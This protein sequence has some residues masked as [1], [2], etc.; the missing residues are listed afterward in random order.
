MSRTLS[1][2][3]KAE[4]GVSTSRCFSHSSLRCQAAM[5]GAFKFAGS[6]GSTSR[7]AASTVSS[8]IASCSASRST[9][10]PRAVLTTM[11]PLPP[12]RSAC[13]A[14]AAA[15]APLPTRPRVSSFS[16]VWTLTTSACPISSSKVSARRTP[17]ASSMPL[18]W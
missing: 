4:C 7:P 12:G 14:L 5:S 1:G 16:G 10:G 3:K 2:V 15:K 18:G 9:I 6:S 8:R 11:M 17:S 13:A